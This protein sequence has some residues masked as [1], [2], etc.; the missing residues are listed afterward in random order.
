[1]LFKN[2]NTTLN[3]L[4]H[5]DMNYDIKKMWF[6]EASWVIHFALSRLTS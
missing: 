1:M 4:K 6:L 2:G 5:I 3:I